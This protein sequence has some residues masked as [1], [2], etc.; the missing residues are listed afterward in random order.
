L[1]QLNDLTTRIIDGLQ[2]LFNT[3]PFSLAASID[4]A[5]VQIFRDGARAIR[6]N[7]VVK[8]I[9]DSPAGPILKKI[10]FLK[11]GNAIRVGRKVLTPTGVVLE[12]GRRIGTES[13]KRLL[14]REIAGIVSKESTRAFSGGEVYDDRDRVLML[15]LWIKAEAI[16]SEE[17]GKDALLH[18]L[19]SAADLK[20]RPT[21]LVRYIIQRATVGD[22]KKQPHLREIKARYMQAVKRLDRQQRIIPPEWT[23]FFKATDFSA[24]ESFDEK[25]LFSAEM[26]EFADLLSPQSRWKQRIY[27]SL[28]SENKK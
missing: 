5:T 23:S 13:F 21:T 3:F 19:K 24:V 4:V 22:Q 1:K 28:Q 25:N 16:S 10:P 6:D 27:E 8:G 9:M 17:A 11:I 7:P 2:S 20:N 12:A 15:A 14:L 18:F 26:R